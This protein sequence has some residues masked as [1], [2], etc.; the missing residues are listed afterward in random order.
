MSDQIVVVLTLV[1]MLVGLAGVVIPFIPGVIVVGAAA[2][3]STFVFGI[4]ASGWL[5]VGT[6]ALIALGGAG[7]SMALPARRGLRGDAARSSLA[8]AAALGLVGFFA[9]PIVGLPLGALGG[10]FI[11]ELNRHG[12]RSRAWA[13]TLDVTKAYGLGVLVELGAALLIIAIWLPGAVL[14]L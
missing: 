13:S 2:I 12:D 10:L 9:I 8:L 4:T 14:R 7:A 11:G 5:L 6:V 1:V 3:V